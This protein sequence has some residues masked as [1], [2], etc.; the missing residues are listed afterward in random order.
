MYFG[1][2]SR[3]LASES[4]WDFSI[5]FW[6]IVQNNLCDKHTVMTLARFVQQ[7]NLHRRTLLL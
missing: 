3:K 7:H 1:R 4:L 5:G 2:L 6:I